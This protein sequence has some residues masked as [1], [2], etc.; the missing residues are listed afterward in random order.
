MKAD[1]PSTGTLLPLSL[2]SSPS[3]YITVAYR[4]AIVRLSRVLSLPRKRSASAPKDQANSHFPRGLAFYPR[5]QGERGD[6][7]GERRA[8]AT[9]ASLETL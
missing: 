4:D 6:F 1:V 2:N 3:K 5:G 9:T 7:G 8:R